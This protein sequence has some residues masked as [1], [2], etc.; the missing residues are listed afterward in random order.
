MHIQ[1]SAKIKGFSSF[2]VALFWFMLSPSS[3]LTNLC[4]MHVIFWDLQSCLY[5]GL[6]LYITIDLDMVTCKIAMF[7]ELFWK[8]SVG[9]G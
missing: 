9:G 5:I 8:F 7:Y 2:I 1:Q 3:P 6:I 4:I